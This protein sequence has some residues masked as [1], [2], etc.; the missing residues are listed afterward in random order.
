MGPC[1]HDEFRGALLVD[2]GVD[3]E[4]VRHGQLGK[5]FHRDD[6]GPGQFERERTVHPVHFE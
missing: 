4:E 1:G 3:V 6:S 2:T 5:V